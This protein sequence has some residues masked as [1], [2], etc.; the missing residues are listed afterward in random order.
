MS[1]DGVV[2]IL[3][4]AGRGERCGGDAPK[5]FQRVG[6]LPLVAHAALALDR[7]PLVDAL[8]VVVPP[9]SE[10]SS[11]AL[12][13]QAGVGAKLRA[14]VAGGATRQDSV[15]NGLHAA[16]DAAWVLV[17]DAARPFVAPRWIRDTL[18]AARRTGAATI[19]TPVGDTLARAAGGGA[20]TVA[21]MLD[22]DGVWSVQ[23]PQVFA[24]GVL[25]E[26]HERARAGAHTATDDGGLV[27][28][29]GR[30]VELVRGGWWNVKITAR[31]DLERAE[32]LFALRERLE[33]AE[34]A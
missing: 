12:L 22:R 9:G 17:H 11:R 10:S 1:Q 34:P 20:D 31:T 16:G 6:G 24:T 4:A 13:A 30:P 28:A 32:M 21:A 33:A 19:A 7:S 14:V 15:W 5:Q 18:A 2:A 26:A 29:M 23:T 3:A 8:V 25:R 27:V